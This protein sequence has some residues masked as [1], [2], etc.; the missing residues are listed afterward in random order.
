M[1]RTRRRRILPVVFDGLIVVVVVKQ[2]EGFQLALRNASTRQTSEADGGESARRYVDF[3][4]TALVGDQALAEQVDVDVPEQ[5]QTAVQQ[6][7]IPAMSGMI[8]FDSAQSP[9]PREQHV[10][11]QS[12]E[13]ITNQN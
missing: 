1:T 4:Q 6:D 8:R 10:V 2:N 3:R 7:D 11:P 9:F 12:R 5:S 13:P